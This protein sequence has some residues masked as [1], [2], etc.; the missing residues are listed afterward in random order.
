MV[1]SEE[2]EVLGAMLHGTADA[3]G[4][5]HRVCRN[6]GFSDFI[7]FTIMELVDS[8]VTFPLEE[9]DLYIAAL[10]V[11]P[12]S[13]GRGIATAL[14]ETAV[15]MGV[16]GGFRRLALDVDPGN[17]AAINLYIKFGFRFRVKGR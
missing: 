11:S 15:E 13:R 16:E 7:R 1:A 4:S 2:Q 8:T 14:L 9:D 17:E 3:T 5:I 10:A 12:E 6:L